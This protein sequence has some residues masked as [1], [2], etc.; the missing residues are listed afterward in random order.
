MTPKSSPTNPL[1]EARHGNRTTRCRERKDRRWNG[2]D[3][4][5]YWP[6]I[7]ETL[8][9]VKVWSTSSTQ[10]AIF[11]GNYQQGRNSEHSWMMN[12]EHM[13]RQKLAQQENRVHLGSIWIV[14]L[15]ST[16]MNHLKITPCECCMF[17]KW[18]RFNSWLSKGLLLKFYILKKYWESCRKL[19][20]WK[21]RWYMIRDWNQNWIKGRCVFNIQKFAVWPLE[22][23][24]NL[25]SL[26][27][28][29]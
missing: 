26:V 17:W 10:L 14:A 23:S 22:I 25:H 29:H 12:R 16:L 6:E 9:C 3:V 5:S 13:E 27:S 15:I 2:S 4:L 24:L 19:T 18:T 21:R 28:A 20:S 7:V 1:A 11:F 8:N